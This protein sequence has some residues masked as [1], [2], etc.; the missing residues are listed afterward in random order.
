LE[1]DRHVKILYAAEAGSRA[2]DFASADSDYDVRF[3]YVRPISSYISIA[4]RRDVIEPKDLAPMGDIDLSGWDVIKALD[5]ASRSNPALLEWL[6]SPI[7]YH[8]LGDFAPELRMITEQYSAKQLLH[9]YSS[10]AK[11]QWM[12]YLNGTGE[13]I[14]YKKYL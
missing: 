11:R 9:H 1:R 5:L 14:R 7:I 13:K 2:W 10:M 12:T 4:S 8:E 3:I 6:R